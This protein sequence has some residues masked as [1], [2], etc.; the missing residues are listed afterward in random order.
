MELDVESNHKDYIFTT[1]NAV[2]ANTMSYHKTPLK[3]GSV[4]VD[5][6]IPTSISDVTV[7]NVG[8]YTPDF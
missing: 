8:E 2:Q 1:L 6:F 3:Y 5:D 7:L 4:E